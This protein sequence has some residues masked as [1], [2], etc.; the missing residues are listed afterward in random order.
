[1]QMNAQLVELAIR[2]PLSISIRICR[3]LRGEPLDDPSVIEDL[4]P[5]SES[6]AEQDPRASTNVLDD[7]AEDMDE[8]KMQRLQQLQDANLNAN[9]NAN[10]DSN[11]K[12]QTRTSGRGSNR[13]RR[14]S[15]SV[16]GGTGAARYMQF[17]RSRRR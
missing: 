15:G 16:E 6:K 9:A 8:Q 11:D 7:D 17:Q 2:L 12:T 1:M 10:A 13:R 3:A 5:E 4:E 14:G